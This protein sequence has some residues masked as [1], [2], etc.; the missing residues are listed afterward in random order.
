[1]KHKILLIG[2]GWNCREHLEKV[3]EPW[4]SLKKEFPDNIFFSVSYGQFPEVAQLN[5]S[6]VSDGSLDVLNWHQQNGNIDSLFVAQTPMYEHELRN[7]SLSKAKVEDYDLVWLLDLQ[8]EIYTRE[9]IMA[10]LKF[11]DNNLEYDWFKLSFKNFFRDEKTYYRPLFTAPRL[12]LAKR[13]GNVGGFFYDND[14]VYREGLEQRLVPYTTV[15]EDVA[16]IKHFSW[17]GSKQRLKAKIAFQ[18][19]HYQTSSFRWDNEKNELTFNENYYKER[20]ESVP[21]LF[22]DE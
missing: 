9:N 10:I 11:V 15:P 12:W 13:N 16:L 5:L 7:A 1:M 20:G 17:N 18:I 3:L 8:D 19:I 4:I 21:E 6:Q 2:L 22:Q 14:M